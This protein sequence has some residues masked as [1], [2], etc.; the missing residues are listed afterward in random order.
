VAQWSTK[1][2]DVFLTH[3]VQAG[4]AK[5]L[6]TSIIAFDIA[7]F[8]PSL[9]HSILTSILRHFGFADCIMGF[10]SNYLVDRYTQYSWNSF[11]SETCYADVGVGQGSALPSILSAL[12]IAPLIQIFEYNSARAS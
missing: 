9:N 10:F 2:A 6:K 1:D 12:Y 4:W 8:F 3:L 11:L 5:G 7:Q